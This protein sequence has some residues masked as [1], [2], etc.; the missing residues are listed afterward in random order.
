MRNNHRRKERALFPFC[1]PTTEPEFPKLY[2]SSQSYFMDTQPVIPNQPYQLW[3]EHAYANL[4]SQNLQ[5]I[6]VQPNFT[7]TLTVPSAGATSTAVRVPTTGSLAVGQNATLTFSAT[8]G[9]KLSFNV[10][11]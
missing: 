9:Q 6:S 11:S 8:A 1:L 2:P 7:G 4:E 5:I 10:L 3:V